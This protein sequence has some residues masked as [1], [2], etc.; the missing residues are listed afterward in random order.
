MARSGSQAYA[1]N[2]ATLGFLHRLKVQC[3]GNT[4]TAW[5]DGELQ[6]TFADSSFGSEHQ[7]TLSWRESIL[8]TTCSIYPVAH[9]DAIT[10]H[11]MQPST[12]CWLRTCNHGVPITSIVTNSSGVGTL[13]SYQ[14]YFPAAL[15][16]DIG[17]IDYTSRQ[18]FTHLGRRC[19]HV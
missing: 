6:Y 18:R 9:S 2:G 1:N 17:N 5:L 16:I 4:H 13:L 12:S 7:S 19:A 10:V 15:S 3:I 11:G 8:V 14:L